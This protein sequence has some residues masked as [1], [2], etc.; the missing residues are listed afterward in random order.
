MTDTIAVSVNCI[1]D[2]NPTHAFFQ[3]QG[4]TFHTGLNGET[5]FVELREKPSMLIRLEAAGYFTPGNESIW[6]MMS[7]T[8]HGITIYICNQE[9]G[10]GFLFIPFSNILA[11]HT[12]SEK[13]LNNV[14][15]NNA[16][17]IL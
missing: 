1:T 5:F 4:M 15:K 17:R 2:S 3:A 16:K 14:Q 6:D 12:A 9:A 11:V 10:D 8:E 7:M 13:W